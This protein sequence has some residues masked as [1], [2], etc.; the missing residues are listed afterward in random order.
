[1]KKEKKEKM[2]RF[3]VSMTIKLNDQGEIIETIPEYAEIPEQV[4]GKYFLN[5][6]YRSG[7]AK[8]YIDAYMNEMIEESIAKA[9]QNA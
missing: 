9:R 2:V 6:F 5:A 3:P 7:D 1:M 4:L 8:E